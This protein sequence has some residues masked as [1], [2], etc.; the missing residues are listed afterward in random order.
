MW[1][2]NNMD[3]TPLDYFLYFFLYGPGI[4]MLAGLIFII[5]ITV[6]IA[7][8]PQ[9]KEKSLSDK[10]R[11]LFKI[12]YGCYGIIGMLLI[13]GGI[14][15]LCMSERIEFIV[16]AAFQFTLGVLI[17]LLSAVL[18]RRRYEKI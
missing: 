11:T 3:G 10:I 18:L 16:F 14:V 8:R 9:K 15:S 17:L 12:Y 2:E 13:I 4:C 6:L 1:E 7:K 5:V